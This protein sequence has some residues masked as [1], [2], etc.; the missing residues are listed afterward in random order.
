[1]LTAAALALSSCSRRVV[2]GTCKKQVSGY[3]G[4]GYNTYI[5]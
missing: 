1:M 4:L 3:Y 5:V 2:L